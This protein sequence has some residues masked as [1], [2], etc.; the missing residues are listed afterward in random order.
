MKK[1]FSLLA[2]LFASQLSY[3]QWTSASGNTT[4]TDKVGIGTASPVTTLDVSGSNTNNP[5][6]INRNT[7]YGSTDATGTSSLGFYFTDHG[8]AKIEASKIAVNITD[9]KLYGE[10]GFNVPSP[11]MTLRPTGLTLGNVGIGTTTPLSGGA[12][13]SWL[14]LNGTSSYSG[15]VV[16]SINGTAKGFSYIDNDGLFTQ[17]AIS[18]GQKFVV[19]G[20]TTAMTML[21]SGN[22]GIGTTSPNG[23]LNIFDPTAGNSLIVLSRATN[24]AVKALDITL[25]SD[26]TVF[27]TANADLNFKTNFNGG[28]TLSTMYLNYQGNVAIGTT[29]PQGHK[30]AVNGD[31][32]ATK[33]T[34]K[35]YGNWPDYVFKPTY[36]LPSLSEVKTYI[37]QN[38]HLPDI[39]SAATV[40]KDGQDIGE[41]N[42]LLLKKVEELTL[43]LIEEQKQNKQQQVELDSL[44]QYIKAGK[45]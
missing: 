28:A 13:A 36:N 30:L 22:I 10:Y 24:P 43:Y 27:T 37:D 3:A 4:T 17:Q 2:I 41:M 38:H 7:S 32:I 40:E 19:N 11:I 31:I 15:G 29:D 8:A 18:S 9:L 1:L 44:K 25:D 12:A 23:K 34:V 45:Y 39:P 14:T 26:N 20:T 16:Y 33:I 35:P 42:K 6:V 21:S 5:T